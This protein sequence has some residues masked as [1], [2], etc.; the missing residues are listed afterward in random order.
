ME[1]A[2]PESIRSLIV[3]WVNP[4][5]VRL[6]RGVEKVAQPASP[7]H[8]SRKARCKCGQCS[9]CLEDARWERIFAEKFED[10]NYYSRPVTHRGSPFTCL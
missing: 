2:D 7:A 6:R 3:G 1:L 9:Q 4:A 8:M 10:P 5:P